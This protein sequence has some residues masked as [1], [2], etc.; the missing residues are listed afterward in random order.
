MMN[1]CLKFRRSF[2][3]EIVLVGGGWLYCNDGVLAV[4]MNV[5]IDIQLIPL[6]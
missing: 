2:M 5:I 3:V 4:K 1:N 6:I